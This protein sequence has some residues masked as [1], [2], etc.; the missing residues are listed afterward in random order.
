MNIGDCLFCKIVHGEVPAEKVYEDKD[1]VAFL[2]INPVN[3]GHVLV[4]PRHHYEN[5]FDAPDTVLARLMVA[6]K[7]ITQKLR[8][9]LGVQDINIGM[10]NGEHAGQVVFHAHIHVMPRTQADGYKLWQGKKYETGE[11]EK[12]G[13]KLRNAL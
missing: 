5:I 8:N 7:K 13:A 10:N 1:S 12:I 11:A 3:P 4:V 9:G 6:T 2:D